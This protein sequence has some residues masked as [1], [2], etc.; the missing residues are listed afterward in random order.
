M[1]MLQKVQ[2]TSKLGF[3]KKLYYIMSYTPIID[4]DCRY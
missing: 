2:D 3:I 4:I 1:K